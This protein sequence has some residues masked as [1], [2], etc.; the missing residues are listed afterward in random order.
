VQNSWGF[1]HR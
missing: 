1:G